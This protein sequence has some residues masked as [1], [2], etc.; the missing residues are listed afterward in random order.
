MA[1]CLKESPNQVQL[2]NEEALRNKSIGT[3][4]VHD[5]QHM[6]INFFS[7]ITCLQT[8]SL[9]G[10]KVGGKKLMKSPLRYSP[11]L[12]LHGSNKRIHVDKIFNHP[13]NVS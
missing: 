6:T 1:Y 12:I 3:D 2:D 8:F 4:I 5:A 7:H 10:S 11:F 9:L 13:S